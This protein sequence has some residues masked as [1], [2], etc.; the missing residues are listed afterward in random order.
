MHDGE[1]FLSIH[2]FDI[3]GFWCIVVMEGCHL[4]LLL[5]HIHQLQP[6]LNTMPKLIFIKCLKSTSVLQN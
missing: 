3:T 2:K 6:L 5:V 1:L 4:N